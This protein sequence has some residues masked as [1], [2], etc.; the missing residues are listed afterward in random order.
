VQQLKNHGIGLPFTKYTT[1]WPTRV[2][3][4]K[5]VTTTSIKT[6]VGSGGFGKEK[7]GKSLAIV[8]PWWPKVLG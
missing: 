2:G 6:C 3:V 7:L 8:M 5:E 4:W 1:W